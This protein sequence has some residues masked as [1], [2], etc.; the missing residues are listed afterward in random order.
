[1]RTICL[2]LCFL[3]YSIASAQ[4]GDELL[5]YSLQGDVTVLEGNKETKLKIGKVLK[6]GSLIKTKK[7]A[8]LTMVC[9]E[10]R[11][12]AVTKE[13]NYPVDLW[14][15]SCATYQGSVT[16]RYF[17]YIWD[18]M[19]V[20]SDDYKKDIAGS[21]L[22]DA[23]VR[24]SENQEL[25]FP[26]KPDTIQYAAGVF[27]IS[28]TTKFPYTG[29]Y[30]FVMTNTRTKNVVYRDS[31][32]AP[33]RSLDLLKKY[34]K[35]GNC[36]S[37]TIKTAFTDAVEGGIICYST[38]GKRNNKISNLKKISDVPED[39]SSQSF[40]IA[41]MLEQEGW[42]ADAYLHYRK[43]AEADPSIEFYKE[44]LQDFKTR[45]FISN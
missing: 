1:M 7:N 38:P 19:Y 42:L 35:P 5:V 26:G 3:I 12:I 23:P 18:Q 10:G 17:Q 40:R 43:A 34:M 20:R 39:L 16:S 22:T 13:G 41:Y 24:G 15:D 28:W 4:K 11:P 25:F 14:R 45:M 44:M 31:L 37:W 29:P 2:I 8:K 32:D 36:Y 21:G 33:T 27:P 9:K 6:K 30:I